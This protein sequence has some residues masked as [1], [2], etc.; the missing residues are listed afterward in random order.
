[1]TDPRDPFAEARKQRGT[2]QVRG[3][4]EDVTFLLRLKDVRKAAK[5]WKTF[6]SD[7][8]LRV[9]IH[10][11]A[12]VRSV[13]QLPIEIDPPEQPE[14]RAVVEPLFRRPQEPDYI[15]DMEALVDR[16][17]LHAIEQGEIEAVSGFSLPLQSY[18]LTRLFRIPESEAEE[19]I[20]WGVHVF[21]H[22]GDAVQEG[23]F[24]ESYSGRKFKE[25]E[26]NPGDDFFTLLNQAEFR[27]RALTFEEKQGYASVALSGGRDTVIHTITSM[28]VILGEKPELLD[29]LREDPELIPNAV[30]EFVRYVSPLTHIAR[31]CPHATQV[32]EQ[33]IDEQGRVAL[34]WPSANRDENHFEDPDMYKVDRCPNPHIG[35]GFGVHT[36]LG[37]P[38]ARLIF[39]SLLKSLCLRVER[40]DVMATEPNIETESSFKR[41][42]GY[43]SARL[44]LVSRDERS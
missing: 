43:A 39:R 11:E 28:L 34:C 23:H 32:A 30:E 8:P 17:V 10:S 40:I 3:D 29:R 38:H 42:N 37:A 4:D 13:R 35:F 14:Y 18:A 27:G 16:Q 22:Q 41:Q 2:L 24:L 20:G 7:H 5:D 15:A 19:W 6:S 1:M 44:C 33:K 9:L 26:E 36:C 25:A 21:Y 12:S 31:T